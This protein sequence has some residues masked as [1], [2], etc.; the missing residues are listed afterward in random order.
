MALLTHHRLWL[1]IA[2][3]S[4]ALAL[5]SILITEGLALQPCHLCI[6]QR[7][8]FMLITPLAFI[9]ALTKGWTWRISGILA[10]LVALV[11]TATAGYRS[12]RGQRLLSR[13][14]HGPDRA[15]RRMA[16]QAATD[17]AHG[18]RFLRGRGL[19]HPRAITGAMVAA[20][21]LT[22]TGVEPVATEP[23]AA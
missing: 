11:G 9:A 15:G 3:A 1:L 14:R 22:R 16:R 20:G 21:I 7:L 17:T 13:P 19:G 10:T 12:T 4:A 5:A 2:S 23:L 18:H 6:F 8:L